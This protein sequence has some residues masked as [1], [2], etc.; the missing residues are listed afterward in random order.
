MASATPGIVHNVN[1]LTTVDAP[2]NLTKKCLRRLTVPYAAFQVLLDPGVTA[3]RLALLEKRA[4]GAVFENRVAPRLRRDTPN[5]VPW[6][7]TLSA[8]I[9]V[10]RKIRRERI[11][12]PS[13]RWECRVSE[14]I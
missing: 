5:L 6:A 1:V 13:G 4:R 10:W 8:G 12:V 14:S 2:A 7:S 11:T 9:I 3:Q